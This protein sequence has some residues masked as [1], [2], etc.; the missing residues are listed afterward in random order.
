[1]FDIVHQLPRWTT[2]EGSKVKGLVCFTTAL[3]LITEVIMREG[4]TENMPEAMKVAEQMNTMCVHVV[5]VSTF[6]LAEQKPHQNRPLTVLYAALST[7]Y[8]L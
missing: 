4:G 5:S 6:L 1:M 2:G 7:L 8:A 3:T